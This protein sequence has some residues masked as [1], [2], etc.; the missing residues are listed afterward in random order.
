LTLR[1][2]VVIAPG[3]VIVQQHVQVLVGAR[4]E[5]LRS[6]TLRDAG[7]CTSH[8]GINIGRRSGVGVNVMITASA[9][10]FQEHMHVLVSTEKKCL[11]VTAANLL[12]RKSTRTEQER[13]PP[14]PR[15]SSAKKSSL[16]LFCSR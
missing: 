6:V 11:A 13:K 1:V 14:Q 10:V 16:D 2:K 15:A 9:V 12:G 3:A 8:G 5:S 7:Q 4:E